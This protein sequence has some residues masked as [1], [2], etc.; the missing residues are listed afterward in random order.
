[1]QPKAVEGN[2]LKGWAINGLAWQK[3]LLV[4][5]NSAPQAKPIKFPSVNDA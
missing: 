4:Y 5:R 1:M 2:P 3:G